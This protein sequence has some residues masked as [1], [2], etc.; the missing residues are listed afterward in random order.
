MNDLF[1]LDGDS[2]SS[3]RYF[4][5]TVHVIHFLPLFFFP[6]R[7]LILNM[8]GF[9]VAFLIFGDISSPEYESLTVHS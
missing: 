1:I 6:D 5:F 9:P 2:K 7:C 3:C 4:G 8:S